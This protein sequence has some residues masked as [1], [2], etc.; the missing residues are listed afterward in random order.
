[1]ITG[2]CHC[3]AVRYEIEGEPVWAGFCHCRNCQ[4]L[5]GTGHAC[6]M[7][8]RSDK[9][10]VRGETRRYP[11][12]LASGVTLVRRFC[13]TCGSQ[14][15]GEPGSTPGMANVYAGTLDDTALFRPTDAI[16]T[17][18]RPPWDCIS[19]D[20]REYAGHPAEEPRP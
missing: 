6:Y 13:P 19:G 11:I 15:F 10:S 8:V 4:R 18:T 16:F 7:G 9:L 12:T 5:T 2:G 3:G 14:I 20:L 17:R 1:M